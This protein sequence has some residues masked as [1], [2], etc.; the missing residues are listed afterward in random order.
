MPPEYEGGILIV[1]ITQSM[2]L[3]NNKQTYYIQE[4]PKGWAVSALDDTNILQGSSLSENSYPDSRVH[5]MLSKAHDAYGAHRDTKKDRY[6]NDLRDQN[7]KKY[8]WN[9]LQ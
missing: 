3:R 4:G 5:L 9:I 8:H 7:N 2:S 6:L 1:Q